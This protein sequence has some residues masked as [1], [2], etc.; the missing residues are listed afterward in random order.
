MIVETESTM[1]ED[2]SVKETKA[3]KIVAQKAAGRLVEAHRKLTGTSFYLGE[4]AVLD[5]V[6]W[7]RDGRAN[8]LVVKVEEAVATSD[9]N[10][11]LAKLSAIVKI[12][13][14][15]FWMTSDAGYQKPS[16]VWKTLADVKLSCAM[17]MPDLQ[18]VKMDYASVVSNLQTLQG[19]TMMPGY[20]MGKGFFLGARGDVQRFKLR[21][22]LFE[23]VSGS[24]H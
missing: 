5:N 15:D 19:R 23:E 16:V 10:L 14:D 22:V 2:S 8:Q 9:T 20:E 7:V 18:P 4:S 12:D 13:C 21:H 17:T 3:P 1:N 11:Q 6:E 24:L